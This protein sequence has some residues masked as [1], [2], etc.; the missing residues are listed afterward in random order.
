MCSNCSGNPEGDPNVNTG[1]ELDLDIDVAPTRKY[2][3][4]CKQERDETNFFCWLCGAELV[5]P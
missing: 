1:D 2:C 4:A 3:A 5:T